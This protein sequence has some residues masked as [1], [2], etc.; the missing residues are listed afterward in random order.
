MFRGVAVAAALA[1]FGAS[2]AYAA[3]CVRP[4]E[5]A[6]LTA[7]VVQT[8]MMV[9]ALACGQ[10]A[11]YNAFVVKF[12]D[13]LMTH[14]HTLKSLFKRVHGANAERRLATF[15]TKLANDASQ[16]S[17][18][19]VNF[20]M[21]AYTFLDQAMTS[22]AVDF[23]KLAATHNTSVDHGFSVCSAEQLSSRSNPVT[24]TTTSATE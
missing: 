23:Q 13:D 2:S 14:G 17:R 24:V 22:V 10:Q 19:A 5:E 20:C 16:R 1:A 9:A 21:E 4:S 11:Q 8:E 15:V 18:E 6:A 7:R 3:S 12:R